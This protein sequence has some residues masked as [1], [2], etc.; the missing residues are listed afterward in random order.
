MKHNVKFSNGTI[1]TLDC[2]LGSGLLDCKGKE[3]F[4]GDIVRFL[5]D[6]PGAVYWIAGSLMLDGGQNHIRFLSAPL[7]MFESEQLEIVGRVED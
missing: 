1:Q 7:D 5:D 6:E 3:I 2:K 4:E